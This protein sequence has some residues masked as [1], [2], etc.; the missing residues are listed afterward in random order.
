MNYNKCF[1]FGSN[2]QG[3]HGAGTAGFALRGEAANTWRD[4]PIMKAAM[5]HGPGY[6]GKLA[7]FGVARGYQEGTKGCSYAIATV[8]RPGHRRSITLADITKQ[9]M[10]LV[11]FMRLN[12]DVTFAMT[13]FGAGYAGYTQ[14][15]MQPIWDCVLKEPNCRWSTTVTSTAYPQKQDT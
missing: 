9:V 2:E 6:K 5:A 11:A 15:E 1:I 12:P 7:T 4:C 14:E 8:T 10:R 13:P 3:F